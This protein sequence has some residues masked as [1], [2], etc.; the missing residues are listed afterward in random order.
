MRTGW[1]GSIA[2]TRFGVVV[3][4]ETFVAEFDVDDCL[5]E[6]VDGVEQAVGYAEAD[7]GTADDCGSYDDD[8]CSAT[9]AG[10][11]NS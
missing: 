9:G 4:V 1:L 11:Y 5:A 2:D 10:H 3:S 7:G 6:L 8:G